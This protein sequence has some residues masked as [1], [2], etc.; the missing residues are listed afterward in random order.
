MNKWTH[1]TTQRRFMPA[2]AATPA[3]FTMIPP[4]YLGGR[5]A[6]SDKLRFA[7]IR[8]GGRGDRDINEVNSEARL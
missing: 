5:G 6:P 1:R 7:D 2:A 8:V 4:H 3:A